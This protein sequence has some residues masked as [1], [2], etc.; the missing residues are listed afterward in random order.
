MTTLPPPSFVSP[1]DRLIV[2]QAHVL[3]AF[4]AARSAGVSTN[5]GVQRLR[6]VRHLLCD[7]LAVVDRLIYPLLRRLA[8]DDAQVR[9]ALAMTNDAVV[10]AQVSEFFAR[11]SDPGGV[12][13]FDDW[14]DVY[15][16]VQRRFRLERNV[17]FPALARS[18]VVSELSLPRTGSLETGRVTHTRIALEKTGDA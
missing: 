10:S 17:L 5:E 9:R 3:Q 4:D 8:V 11:H 2:E 16:A 13:F 6:A 1:L 18:E 12:E 14:G 15:V 7:H